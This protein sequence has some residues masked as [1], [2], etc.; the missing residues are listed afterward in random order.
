LVERSGWVVLV[1]REE[2]QELNNS[3]KA[4]STVRRDLEVY[5]RNKKW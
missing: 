5:M 3:T 1:W 2:A 4:I